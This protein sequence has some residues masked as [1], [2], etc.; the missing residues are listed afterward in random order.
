MDG[1]KLDKRNFL[2]KYWQ[3]QPLLIPAALDPFIVPLSADE[4]AGLALEEHVESRI[5]EYRDGQWCSIHGPFAE[6]DFKRSAPWTLL[7]QSVDHHVP[8]VA[9]LR[10]LVDFIPQWRIDDVMMSYAVDGGSAG[11]HYDNYDVFLLQG[12]GERLWR[13]GQR[14]HR[15][16][17]KLSDSEPRI[18]EEFQC[19][20][21]Y[22]L[23]S[24]DILYI[25][26]GVA[27][28]GIARGECTTFSIGF[29]AP[30]VVDLISRW[31]D[32]VLE[33]TDASLF[34]ADSTRPKDARPGEISTREIERAAELVR[35]T[36]AADTDGRWF[37]ELVTEAKGDFRLDHTELESARQRLGQPHV[38]TLSPAAKLAW[39]QQ[40]MGITVFANG[41]CRVFSSLILDTLVT[42]CDSWRI[43]NASLA[44]ALV[45]DE[46]AELL[47]F[48]LDTGCIDVK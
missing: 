40:S 9:E 26:P 34:Y 32:S 45:Q 10:K 2:D 21:E 18:I 36:I 20:Q 25:P 22:L 14:C 47:E 44:N 41:E 3:R 30:R 48:L 13:L 5:I 38:V 6:A 11:P 23:G 33:M 42:L 28:W 12:E 39:M 43:S 1:L 15:D 37:G 46:C 8:P 27:H 17:P 7:V 29:R 4:L 24:G 31:A 35:R 16:T 19:E